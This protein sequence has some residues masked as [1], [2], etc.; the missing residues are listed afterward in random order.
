MDLRQ[1]VCTYLGTYCE[2]PFLPDSTETTPVLQ[3]KAWSNQVPKA[4]N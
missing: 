4:E 2:V 3:R 1:A